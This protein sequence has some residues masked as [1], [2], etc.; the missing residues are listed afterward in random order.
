M[1]TYDYN[2]KDCDHL[3]E[4]FKTISA[5]DPN[6]C[7]ECGGAVEKDFRHFGKRSKFRGRVNLYEARDLDSMAVRTDQGPEAKALDNENGAPYTEYVPEP[8]HPE[9][10]RP[11]MKSAK[12]EVKYLRAHDM[13][14][15]DGN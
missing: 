2:C 4:V 10:S 15:R 3:F 6:G 7:P 14:N 8:G 13:F 11:R 12:H 5:D 9:W 1:P